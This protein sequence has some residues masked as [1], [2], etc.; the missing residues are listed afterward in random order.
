M[1]KRAK[2]EWALGEPRLLTDDDLEKLTAMADA[3]NSIAGDNLPLPEV[4][5][6][7]ERVRRLRKMVEERRDASEIQEL[8]EELNCTEVLQWV[9][10]LEE[11]DRVIDKLAL[12]LAPADE[13]EDA[14][15]GD[16]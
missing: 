10:A 7:S 2:G 6:L 1:R 11:G 13:E 5:R 3:M 4:D 14:D 15:G 9:Q 8:A 16:D 12:K